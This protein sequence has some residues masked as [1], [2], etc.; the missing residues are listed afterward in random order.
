[1]VRG[2]TKVFTQIMIGTDL[3]INNNAVLKAFFE[4]ER[5]LLYLGYPNLCIMNNHL[6]RL[7]VLLLLFYFLS[8]NQNHE[9]NNDAPNTQFKSALNK[10]ENSNLSSTLR[11]KNLFYAYH[12][13]MQLPTDSLQVAHYSHIARIAIKIPDSNMFELSNTK[14]SLLAVKIENSYLRA[15]V[16]WNMAEFYLQ[17]EIP[18]YIIKTPSRYLRR[19]TMSFMQLKCY[20]IWPT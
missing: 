9:N 16:K 19:P 11:K 10:A 15:D 6:L 3:H 14:A 2:T 13:N 7:C 18:I 4:K 8:C 1:M 17:D 5:L 20:I 12:A